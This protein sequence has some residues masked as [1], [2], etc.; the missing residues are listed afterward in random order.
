MKF[1]RSLSIIPDDEAGELLIREERMAGCG[2]TIF[3]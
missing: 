1:S 3:A 2:K